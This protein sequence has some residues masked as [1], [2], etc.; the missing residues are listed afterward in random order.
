LSSLTKI[1]VFLTLVFAILG[2]V[3]EVVAVQREGNYKAQVKAA[4]DEMVAAQAVAAEGKVTADK[5]IAE[6]DQLNKTIG[7]LTSKAR[8]AGEGANGKIAELQG[9]LQAAENSIAKIQNSLNDTTAIANSLTQQNA[10][11]A[12]EIQR[13]SPE[14]VRLT[15]ENAE[16]SRANNELTTANNF[17][18]QSIRKLQEQ[19][20]IL[21]E[22]AGKGGAS[23]A[24]S[25]ANKVASLTVETPAQINGKID[26]VTPTAGRTLVEMPL[27]IRDGVRNG[28]RFM[29]YRGQTYIADAVVE[30][31]DPDVSIAAIDPATLK[32]GQTVQVGDMVMTAANK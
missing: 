2:S 4:N 11:Y 15:R 12:Q 7:D 25:D 10:A 8:V 16:L 6:R 13:L 24:P 20:A 21:T 30:K 1:F 28:T 29:V 27:G 9:K 23:V 19:I 17:A 3:M 31:A 5:L 22:N 18:G 32:Q 26:Q 14:N